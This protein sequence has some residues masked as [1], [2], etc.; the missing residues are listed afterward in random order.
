MMTTILYYYGLF[1]LGI[2]DA[3]S[4]LYLGNKSISVTHNFYWISRGYNSPVL[5]FCVGAHSRL[6][7]GMSD[8]FL[9]NSSFSS[10]SILRSVGSYT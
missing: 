1:L 4:K 7:P 2:V 8:F 10:S 3:Q 6:K 9:L 5:D